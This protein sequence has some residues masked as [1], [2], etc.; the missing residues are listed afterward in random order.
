[1]NL[2]SNLNRKDSS[3]LSKLK[4]NF[5]ND[6]AR[7]YWN[8]LPVD[9]KNSTS[10]ISFKNN[11][12]H[13]RV[14]CIESGVYDGH[15]WEVSRLVLDRVESGSYLENKESHNTYLRSNPFVAKKKFIN[16]N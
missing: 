3:R 5:I 9:V 10:V 8:K 6:R 14:C 2:L 15:Y 1:M 7:E 4:R 13:F 11:L 16:L 12:E